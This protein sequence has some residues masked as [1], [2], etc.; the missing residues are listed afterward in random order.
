MTEPLSAPLKPRGIPPPLPSTLP[1]TIAVRGAVASAPRPLPAQPLVEEAVVAVLDRV[2][3]LARELRTPRQDLGHFAF[4]LFALSRAVR[5]YLWEGESRVDL[6]EVYAPWAIPRCPGQCAVDGVS[7]CPQLRADGSV[8]WVAVG[9]THTLHR[10][11][12]FQAAAP[13]GCPVPVEGNSLATSCSRLGLALLPTVADGDCAVDTMCMMVGLPS[14][15]G[16]RD[17]LRQEPSGR[18]AGSAGSG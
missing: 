9:P 16:T 7:C 3:S 8:E 18:C 17:L 10:A 4:I 1:S 11:N 5:P 13:L 14:S 6:L 2:L 12:H 15:R